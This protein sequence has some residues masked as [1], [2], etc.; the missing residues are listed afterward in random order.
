[1]P[2]IIG[3]PT[4]EEA[5][6]VEARTRQLKSLT[7]ALND[8]LER[9]RTK[10]GALM[11]L[12]SNENLVL[13][14]GMAVAAIT[15]SEQAGLSLYTA[16]MNNIENLFQKFVSPLEHNVKALQEEM[17]KLKTALTACEKTVAETKT[18]VTEKLEGA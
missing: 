2:D 1:M 6:L 7:D 17:E 13:I 3:G 4:P 8:H 11:H 10:L 9:Y 18:W 15:A 16:I 5:A 14:R 12:G